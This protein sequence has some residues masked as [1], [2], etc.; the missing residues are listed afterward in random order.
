MIERKHDFLRNTQVFCFFATF[1]PKKSLFELFYRH[2]SHG[3]IAGS[4]NWAKIVYVPFPTFNKWLV[5]SHFKICKRDWFPTNVAFASHLIPKILS[6]HSVSDSFRTR[7][8]YGGFIRRFCNYE[9]IFCVPQRTV[10]IPYRIAFCHL[11]HAR[12]RHS[13]NK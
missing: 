13:I 9:W 7:L 11:W 1:L 10:S 6:P 8:S 4:A 2:S 3:T 12:T 5:M